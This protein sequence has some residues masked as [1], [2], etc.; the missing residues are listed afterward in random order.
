MRL[1]RTA[2]PAEL[3]ITLPEAKVQCRVDHDD[4]DVY[5]ETLIDAVTDY[6]DGPSGILGRAILQQTWLLELEAWPQ[7]VVL[8]IEPLIS[9]VVSWLDA[10]G[11]ETNLPGTSYDLIMNPSARP[12]L[13]MKAGTQAPQ[14]GSQTY[15]VRI[16]MTA[17]WE[18]AGD[19]PASLKVAMLM[20][21]AHW[22]QR[23][24]PH[25]GPVP[26]AIS[27]LLARWR[28]VL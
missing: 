18:S 28:V 15:P 10:D 2:A 7:T 23:N 14:L 19:L 16:L 3:A 20:L 11:A 17:G 8:P 22:Y 5:I 25:A 26:M 24:S 1:T 4:E 9:V 13:Q 12:V 6:L 21:I 27:A